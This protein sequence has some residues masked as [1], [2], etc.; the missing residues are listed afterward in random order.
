MDGVRSRALRKQLS[1]LRQRLLRLV[2]GSALPKLANEPR[3][4][5]CNG[6]M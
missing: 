2:Q 4:D 3:N 5:Q 6:A 1:E